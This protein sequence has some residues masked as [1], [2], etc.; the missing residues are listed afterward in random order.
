MPDKSREYT[1]T[2][3]PTWARTNDSTR[4]SSRTDG[5]VLERMKIREICEGWGPCNKLGAFLFDTVLT[6]YRSLP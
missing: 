6:T 3:P 1:T 2:Q 4:T 5:A